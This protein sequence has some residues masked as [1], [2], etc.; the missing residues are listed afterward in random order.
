MP[1]RVL[2]RADRARRPDLSHPGRL[3][4]RRAVPVTTTDV[5]VFAGA[6]MLY[7][8]AGWPAVLPVP[9][10]TK[11]P[12]PT[13]YTGAEGLDTPADLLNGWASGTIRHPSGSSYAAY[14]CALRM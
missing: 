11:S 12:P 4:A 13:G 10:E 8:Q 1:V 14:S 3:R 6:A 2:P 5:P 9:P 7:H